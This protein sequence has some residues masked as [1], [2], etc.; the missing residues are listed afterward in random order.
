MILQHNEES[1]STLAAFFER[2]IPA[3]SKKEMAARV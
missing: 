2:R 3:L 1:S